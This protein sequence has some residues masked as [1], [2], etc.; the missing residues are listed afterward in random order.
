MKNYNEVNLNYIRDILEF[1]DKKET[2]S[3]RRYFG[4]LASINKPEWVGKRIYRL[5]IY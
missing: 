1:I 5:Y 2:V 4:D 3:G